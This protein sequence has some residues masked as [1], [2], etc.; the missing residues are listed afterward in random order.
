MGPLQIGVATD[1]LRPARGTTGRG[2]EKGRIR[3][4]S[5]FSSAVRLLDHAGHVGRS[6]LF[7]EELTVTEKR[8]G[9]GGFPR[10]TIFAETAMR[11]TGQVLLLDVRSKGT[12][13][14]ETAAGVRWRRH[15]RNSDEMLRAS[16]R[17]KARRCARG[18]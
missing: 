1:L 13:G 12:A 9:L 7:D 15:A 3:G 4:P 17:S 8:S 18:T 14:E 5:L 16:N 11:E 2:N 10:G 6:L